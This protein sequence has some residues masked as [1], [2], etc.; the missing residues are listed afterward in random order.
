V[1]LLR[2]IGRHAKP[3][4]LS[5]GASTLPEIDHAVQE[6]RAAGGGPVVLLHCVLNYPTPDDQA[7]LGMIRGLGRAFPDAVI[8]YSDHT[9]P[10]PRLTALLIADALGARVLEKHFTHDKS[11]PGNDHYHAMDRG[12]L[13]RFWDDLRTQRQLL[14]PT[15]AKA[16]LLSEQPARDHARRSI[17]LLRAM[18]A[19]DTFTGETLTTKRPGTG[20]SPLHWDDMIGRRA[21]RSLPADHI[22]SWSDVQTVSRPR[23]VAIIQA[24]MG[25]RRFPGKMMASLGGRPLIEWMLARVSRAQHVD[26]VVLATTDLHADDVLAEWARRHGISVVRGDEDDVLR[27][28]VLAADESGAEWVVRVCGDNPFIDPEEI[29]RLIALFDRERP[30]YAFNHLEGLDN[31]YADG[32]GAEMLTRELLGT[33]DQQAHE[34]RHREHVTSYIWDHI[35][36][37]RIVTPPAPPELAF[38]SLKFDIDEP[39]DLERLAPMATEIGIAGRAA[40]FVRAAVAITRVG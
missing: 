30:D 9:V 38:P 17:V 39:E 10:G 16:P 3:V 32:F 21:A 18:R 20:I 15:E 27:R 8:G 25:S 22:L 28:F 19:G 36:A 26:Q 6:V 33:C 31:Q 11:L 24:R 2:R 34:P 1:P 13:R 4:L 23:V 14:G 29:D 35:H 37:F 7:H 40:D 12:D 5:T